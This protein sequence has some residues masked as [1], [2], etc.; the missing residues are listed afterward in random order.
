[1]ATLNLIG[2]IKV[3]RMLF[4][5]F[6]LHFLL[7]STLSFV[8]PNSKVMAQDSYIN[9]TEE[10]SLT[11]DGVPVLVIVQGAESFYVDAVYA[12]NDLL[13]VNIE[14]LFK[15]LNIPCAASQNGTILSGFIENENQKYLVDYNTREVTVG[16]KI[17]NPK[18][19]L[20]KENGMLYLDAQLFAEAF[21]LTLT[22]NFRSLT[23]ILKSNFELPVIKQQKID[24]LRNNVLKIRGEEVVDTTVQRNYHLFKFGTI[25][26]S[27]ASYQKWNE[28]ID[29]RFGLG[30][31][32]ELLYG[33]LNVAV[34][35][36]DRYKFDNRQLYYLWRWV[37]NEKK[38]IKQAQVGKIST[39]S[40][41]FINSPIIGATIRNSPTTVRKAKGT[42]L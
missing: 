28:S 4:M 8:L 38:L 39:Q 26:W 5:R 41:A 6:S 37:D 7:L 36:Y 40:L 18:Y 29:N 9:E 32:T 17:V 15:T 27:V 19:R 1:M 10:S 2:N 20:I 14:D 33:E 35:Y 42:I 21:G 31:G 22:F 3:Y 11:F 16:T 25:D 24:K 23:I 30:I 34:N 13:Y 12:N